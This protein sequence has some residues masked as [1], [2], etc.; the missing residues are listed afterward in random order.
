MKNT[1]KIAALALLAGAM[2]FTGCKKDDDENIVTPGA[3]V[4]VNFNGNQ[5]AID[6]YEAVTDSVF[7]FFGLVA[8]NVQAKTNITV[9]QAGFT[10]TKK[11][12]MD[13]YSVWYASTLEKA[14][15]DEEIFEWMGNEAIAEYFGIQNWISNF[16]Y[17]EFDA[18]SLT[19][20]TNMTATMVNYDLYDPENPEATTMMAPITVN[21]NNV[22]LSYN[23]EESYL[24][25]GILKKGIRNANPF[26]TK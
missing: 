1:F 24:K 10:P 8:A 20:T 21:A 2:M 12:S 17:N 3:T 4:A 16:S 19:L 22:P 15:F 26:A 11:T 7:D 9:M 18:T 25:K 6:S 13:L 23:D 14:D 5:V